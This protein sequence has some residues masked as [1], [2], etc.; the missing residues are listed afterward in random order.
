MTWRSYQAFAR[1]RRRD[2]STTE[3]AELTEIFSLVRFK[4]LD[5]VG[6]LSG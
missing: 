1:P 5:G 2:L 3:A 4:S 6:A